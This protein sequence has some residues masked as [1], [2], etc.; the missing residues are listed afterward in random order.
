MPKTNER[1]CSTSRGILTGSGFFIIEFLAGSKDLLGVYFLDS[2]GSSFA[3]CSVVS[4][5]LLT[6]SAKSI[7]PVVNSTFMFLRLVIVVRCS[8]H[9]SLNSR[10]FSMLIK[11]VAIAAHMAAFVPRFKAPKIVARDPAAIDQ[12]VVP[13]YTLIAT[14]CHFF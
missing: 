1:K 2:I 6:A 10:L 3:Y 5:I 8:R 4:L 9:L 14:V 7:C 13:Q 12:A 11:T